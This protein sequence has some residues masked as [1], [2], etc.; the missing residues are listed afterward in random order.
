MITDKNRND[1]AQCVYV[2]LSGFTVV[3]K[4]LKFIFPQLWNKG[5][6]DLCVSHRCL[7]CEPTNCRGERKFLLFTRFRRFERKPVWKR[8]IVSHVFLFNIYEG[9]NKCTCVTI[10]HPDNKT[11]TILTIRDKEPRSHHAENLSI[12]CLLFINTLPL[13][14]DSD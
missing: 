7:K 8:C 14:I 3:L 12:E 1:W 6:E 5:K 2:K 13:H 11:P 9:F 4:L 10:R